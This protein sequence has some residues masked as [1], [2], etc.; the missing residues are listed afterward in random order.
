MKEYNF[1][2]LFPSPICPLKIGKLLSATPGSV[3]WIGNHWSRDGGE[4]KGGGLVEEGTGTTGKLET[5][6]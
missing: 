4:G 3:G 2:I 1:I 5:I 6:R